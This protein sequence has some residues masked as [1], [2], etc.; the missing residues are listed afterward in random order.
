MIAMTKPQMPAENMFTSISKP[1]LILPS[2]SPSSHF[3]V[4][5]ASGA[6]IMAPM[7][8][9]IWP[10]GAASGFTLSAAALNR[11]MRLS[12]PAITPKVAIEPTTAPRT[13]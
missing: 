1:A 6:M 11:A 5:A 10:S 12:E 8:M 9:W 7:N 2:H 3:I 4:Y 13:P